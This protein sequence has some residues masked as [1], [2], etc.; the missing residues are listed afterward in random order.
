[1]A[2]G[3]VT[4]VNGTPCSAATTSNSS[5]AINARR[6]VACPAQSSLQQQRPLSLP[7]THLQL[8]RRADTPHMADTAK[9]TTDSGN[10]EKKTH[11]LWTEDE[12]AALH[13]G[14]VKCVVQK[15]PLHPHVAA[16]SIWRSSLTGA[17][18]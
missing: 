15:C 1:M 2:G 12:L 3:G 11:V 9:G 16:A 17:R 10:G 4:G 18:A 13:E 14:V 8:S 7:P 6:I 5:T